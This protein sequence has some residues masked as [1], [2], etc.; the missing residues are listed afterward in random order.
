VMNF[1][2]WLQQLIVLWWTSFNCLIR[3]LGSLNLIKIELWE[4]N[5][6]QK[7]RDFGL[8]ICKNIEVMI[9]DY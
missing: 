2:Y 1:V 9:V 8:I 7:C 4:T 5:F 3:W 6:N